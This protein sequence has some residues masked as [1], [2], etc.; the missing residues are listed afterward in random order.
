MKKYFGADFYA[1]STSR[2]FSSWKTARYISGKVNWIWVTSMLVTDVMLMTFLVVGDPFLLIISYY[3]KHHHH[4]YIMII[5]P[6]SSTCLHYKIADIML[7]P[8]SLSPKIVCFIKM[9][10]LFR[11]TSTTQ[12]IEEYSKV[13]FFTHFSFV[14]IERTLLSL[15]STQKSKRKLYKFLM[16]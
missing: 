13:K 15:I 1:D 3:W 16:V 12:I 10:F 2:T 7:S 6:T 14:N 5:S 8:T 11:K 9:N 4:H